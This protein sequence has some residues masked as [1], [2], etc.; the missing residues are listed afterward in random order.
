MRSTRLPGDVP[1]SMPEGAVESL[2]AKG[3]L[4]FKVSIIYCQNKG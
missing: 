4:I 2:N 3:L 1:S